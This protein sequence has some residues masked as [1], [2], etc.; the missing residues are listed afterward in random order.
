MADVEEIAARALSLGLKDR[1]RLTERLLQSL[2]D[3]SDA[4]AEELWAEESERRLHEHRQGKGRVIPADK[5]LS[6]A[7]SLL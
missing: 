2:D 4:E 5:V 6:K 1:A 3:L 7:R